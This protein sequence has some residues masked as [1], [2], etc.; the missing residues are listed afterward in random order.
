MTKVKVRTKIKAKARGKGSRKIEEDLLPEV[1]LNVLGLVF[2]HLVSQ[3]GILA[4]LTLQESA[5]GL[6]SATVGIHLFVLIGARGLA[7]RA[8]NVHFSIKISLRDLSELLQPLPLQRAKQRPKAKLRQ[9]ESLD[10]V[11]S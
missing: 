10:K 9:N 8:N 4:K 6:L 1:T 5:T 3:T 2:P 7:P 11:C